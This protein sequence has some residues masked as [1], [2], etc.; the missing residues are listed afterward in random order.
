MKRLAAAWRRHPLL[1]TG[2]VLATLFTI[3]FA[4]RSVMFMIYWSDPAHRDQALEGWMTPRY[5]A[6]SWHLP[7]DVVLKALGLE[8]MPRRRMTLD[9]IARQTHVPL[10]DLEARIALAAEAWRSRKR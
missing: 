9:R 10:S 2:F 4:I 8:A 1:T 3:M 6:R 5:I 7:D